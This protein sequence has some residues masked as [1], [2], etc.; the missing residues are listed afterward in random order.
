MTTIEQRVKLFK[1][2]QLTY[3]KTLTKDQIELTGLVI[4]E[5]NL[6]SELQVD[7]ITNADINEY[8]ARG[9]TRAGRND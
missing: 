4:E 7:G 8:I 5:A 6:M 1:L 3:N 2:E 9:I